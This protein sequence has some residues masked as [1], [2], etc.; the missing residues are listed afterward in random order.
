MRLA[1]VNEKS[2]HAGGTFLH[3]RRTAFKMRNLLNFWI[4][5]NIKH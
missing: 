1:D 3:Y 5:F 2:L 4:G